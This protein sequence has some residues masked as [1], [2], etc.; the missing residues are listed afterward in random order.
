[1]EVLELHPKVILYRGLFSNPTN[2]IEH[3]KISNEWVAWA[4]FGTKTDLKVLEYCFEKFPSVNDWND[5]LLE[6]ISNKSYQAIEILDIF[7][8]VT[9]D[10]YFNHLNEN[11]PNWQFIDPQICKYE[12]NAGAAPGAAMVYHTDFPQAQADSAGPK[13]AVTCTMYLNDDYEGGEICFKVLKEDGKT[14]DY[15]EHKPKAGDILVFPSRAPYYHGVNK[16]KVGEKYFVRSFWHYKSE[17]TQEWRD[18]ESKYGKDVW[19]E[20]E[21]TRIKAETESGKYNLNLNGVNN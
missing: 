2:I 7:Y 18:N 8:K 1:M 3:Y 17:G 16:T 9:S 4:D 10:Y 12:T 19:A 15:F 11:L 14:Y 21:E 13:A 6:T 5:V 20:M